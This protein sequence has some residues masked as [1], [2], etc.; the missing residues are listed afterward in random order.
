MLKL[1]TST[2]NQLALWEITIL[3]LLLI[4]NPLLQV[5]INI[6]YSVNLNKKSFFNNKWVLEE[7]LMGRS[8][9]GMPINF[10]TLRFRKIWQNSPNH[11]EEWVVPNKEEMVLR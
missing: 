2:S 7:D 11:R 6:S 8:S 4:S 9:K 5:I 1:T 10:R 3:L